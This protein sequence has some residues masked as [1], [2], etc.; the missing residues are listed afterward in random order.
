MK[1]ATRIQQHKK[2]IVDKKMVLKG[3]SDHAKTCK[4]GFDLK[5]T[6]TLKTEEKK[7]ERKVREALEIQLQQTSPRSDHGLNQDNGH[8]VT[9]SFWKPMSTHI[10]EKTLQ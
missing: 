2:S 1:T 4:V 5:G 7:F 8:Y 10:R 6:I 9:T 3:V